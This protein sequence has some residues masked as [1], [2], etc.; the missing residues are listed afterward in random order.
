MKFSIVFLCI[1]GNVHGGFFNTIADVITN[2]PVTNLIAQVDCGSR[3]IYCP[4]GEKISVGSKANGGSCALKDPWGEVKRRC[5]GLGRCTANNYASNVMKLDCSAAAGLFH[6]GPHN[7]GANTEWTCYIHDLC[8]SWTH[9]VAKCNVQM[10]HN[11]R[12]GNQDSATTSGIISAVAIGGEIIA[13]HERIYE[14]CKFPGKKCAD[15]GGVCSCAGGTVVYA[16]NSGHVVE[17]RKQTANSVLCRA[18][19][20][21]HLDAI[22][23]SFDSARGYKCYCSDDDGIWRP[24]NKDGI[25]NDGSTYNRQMT[26]W[27]KPPLSNN[28]N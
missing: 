11:L 2:N 5:R 25:Y 27:S 8:Y 21:G 23:R 3:S 12:A 26:D 7:G 22:A 18:K 17:G 24:D 6:A 1:F 9:D 19:T 14:Y 20:F 4:R 10:Y 15:Y 13:D 16:A 28:K